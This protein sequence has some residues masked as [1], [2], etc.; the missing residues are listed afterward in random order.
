MKTTPTRICLAGDTTKR[1]FCE[2]GKPTVLKASPEG[3]AIVEAMKAKKRSSGYSKRDG[4]I[5]FRQS[6]RALGDAVNA[7]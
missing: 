3:Q 7:V 1:T 4:K 2:C 5:G 6:Q